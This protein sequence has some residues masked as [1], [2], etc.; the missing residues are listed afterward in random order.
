VVVNQD[1]SN[2]AVVFH[3]EVKDGKTKQNQICYGPATG[4]EERIR[5]RSS[6]H[7]KTFGAD[8]KDLVAC[9]V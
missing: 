2:Q 6:G 3:L 8:A 5:N 7:N 9:V 4:T 1:D